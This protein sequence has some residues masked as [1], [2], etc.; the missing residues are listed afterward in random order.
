MKGL[1]DRDLLQ[2]SLLQERVW[3]SRLPQ[4][5][6]I[7]F[8]VAD[9]DSHPGCNLQFTEGINNNCVLPLHFVFTNS[10]VTGNLRG[11]YTLQQVYKIM[12]PV[13]HFIP[14]AFKANLPY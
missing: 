4:R 10:A 1:G 9:R 7:D 11:D 2:K 6:L 3:Q 14:S 5:A 13:A 12:S 8:R